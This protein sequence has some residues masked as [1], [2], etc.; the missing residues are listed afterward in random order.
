MTAVLLRSLPPLPVGARV[1]DYCC[2]A[3]SI[4]AALRLR[5]GVKPPGLVEY[6][7]LHLGVLYVSTSH[8]TA[9]A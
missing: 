6:T 1:L 8:A 2:G 3:G 7:T 5:S 4:G 9:R